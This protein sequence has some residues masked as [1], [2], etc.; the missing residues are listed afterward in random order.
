MEVRDMIRHSYKMPKIIIISLFFFASFVFSLVIA[1]SP[2]FPLETASNW[3]KT[4][5]FADNMFEPEI[6]GAGLREG[7]QV[8][9]EN[10]I[11]RFGQPLKII[12]RKEADHREPKVTNEILTL[13]YAGL[14]ITIAKPDFEKK[15]IFWIDEI[16]V[17]SSDY[18][19]KYG[20]RI[21]QPKNSFLRELG[22]PL[23]DETKSIFYFVKNVVMVKKSFGFESNINIIIE[24]DEKDQ[25]RKIVWES[26][27]D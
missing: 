21:G 9:K 10:L 11:D 3:T 8:T 12:S 1:V 15:P 7:G 23:K 18:H 19:L 27:A 17:T 26:F 24:F 13:E 2:V 22:K 25:A 4:Q 5:F 16:V 14:T 6:P 20:L